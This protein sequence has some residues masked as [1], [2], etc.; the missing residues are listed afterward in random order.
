MTR[1]MTSTPLVLYNSLTRRLEPF[2]RIKE[3]GDASVPFEFDVHAMIRSDD[4]PTLE[5]ELHATFEEHRLN[6]VNYR[7]EFFRVPLQTIREVVAARQLEATFTMAADAR[8]YRESLALAKM[9]PEERERYHVD[10]D[11]GSG[12][13]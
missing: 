1:A 7:K 13:D 6:K 8:E 9:T 2:D 4:A 5:R 10:K 11:E 3:L 12:D